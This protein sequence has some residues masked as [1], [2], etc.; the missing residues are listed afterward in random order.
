M[1]TALIVDINNFHYTVDKA[2][3]GAKLNYAQY[4]EFVK[5]LGYNLLFQEAY[6]KGLGACEEFRK[7]LLDLD[8][9]VFYSN[10]KYPFD[11]CD[12]EICCRAIE[13]ARIHEGIECII[14]G[15]G[16]SHCAPCIKFLKRY[17]P[18]IRIIASSALVHPTLHRVSNGVIMID[19][20]MTFRKNKDEA[21]NA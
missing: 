11:N 10:G 8:F 5:S 15:S 13:I 6:G 14:L 3:P 1:K 4:I 9:S 19:E 16:K 20:K 7:D 18:T 21:G 17:H 12:V 2:W